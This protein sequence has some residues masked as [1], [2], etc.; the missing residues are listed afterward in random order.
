MALEIDLGGDAQ[1]FRDELREW[2]EANRPEALIGVDAERAAYG[3][4]PGIAAWTD[5]LAEAGYICVGWPKRSSSGYASSIS[6]T[7]IV[8]QSGIGFD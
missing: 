8:F 4:I 5:K 6:G 1:K 3:N 7:T 2:L